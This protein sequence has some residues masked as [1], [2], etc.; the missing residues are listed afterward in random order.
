[1]KCKMADFNIELLCRGG[2]LKRSCEPY[3][4]EFD[5]PDF[6]FRV[7]D[8]DIESERA[9]QDPT[10]SKQYIESVAACR[11]L[12]GMLPE[13]S[14]YIL[15]AATFEARGKGIAFLAKS[16]T[17]KST[18][19]FLWQKLLGDE[20]H[21]V[22]GDKPIVRLR[23]GVPHAYGTPWC[24]KEGLNENRE[25]ILTDLCFIRRSSENK[26]VLLDKGEAVNE[27]LG[28]IVMPIG[29]DKL[30]KI[31]EMLGETVEHCRVWEIYCNTD[32]SAAKTAINVIFEESK[33]ETEE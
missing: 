31:I 18:H 10:F 27:L 20:F 28:Q 17:G 16:G 6:S 30:I 24:G 2:L 26:T 9:L 11:K 21:I 25:V 15:H 19:M 22:N 12:S 29:S 32:I 4:E 13:R 3:F 8:E 5:R 1:M 23:D 14:A 7:E 33:N